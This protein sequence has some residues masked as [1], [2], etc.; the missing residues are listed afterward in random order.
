MQETS[1]TGALGIVGSG[2][3]RVE[4]GKTYGFEVDDGVWK[5]KKN[6]VGVLSHVP[7][8]K[9]D[10]MGAEKT[11]ELLSGF[12]DYLLSVFKSPEDG[13]FQPSR[14]MVREMFET[15]QGLEN[16]LNKLF[17][18]RPEA[19]K[20]W[21]N[22]NLFGR[23]RRRNKAME[24]SVIEKEKASTVWER[25]I[26]QI[27]GKRRRSEYYYGNPKKVG[28]SWVLDGLNRLNEIVNTERVGVRFSATTDG[29][30]KENYNRFKEFVR[31]EE[32]GW[33]KA[34]VI[35]TV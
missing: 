24:I 1:L 29:E 18:Q 21:Q 3:R 5:E 13:E 20:A 31:N 6:K 16:D 2:K 30:F 32:V 19:L 4:S 28:G 35:E 22:F 15:T 8:P 23:S 12:K 11:V 7:Q 25:A 9:E 26:E 33:G 34:K 17:I 14:E 10:R 27:D